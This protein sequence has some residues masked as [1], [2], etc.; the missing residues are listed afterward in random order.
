MQNPQ[1]L[2]TYQN[3][4][5]T[6]AEM[7][8]GFDLTNG[9][10]QKTFGKKGNAQQV[11]KC[12]GAS[13]LQMVRTKKPSAKKQTHNKCRNAKGLR[14]YKW[15]EP[16]N[17]RQKSNLKESKDG[18]QKGGRRFSEPSASIIRQSYESTPRKGG[19]RRF[20][21]N[22]ICAHCLLWQQLVNRRTRPAKH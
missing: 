18:C 4:R 16:K 19:G 14:P 21:K 11:Q 12:Q 9:P 20:S 6:S 10:N 5:T 15:S 8:R 1:T 2:H 7:P 22:K 13:T 3:K 17:L